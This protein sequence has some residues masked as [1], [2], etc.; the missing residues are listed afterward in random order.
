MTQLNRREEQK[1]HRKRRNKKKGKGKDKK[2]NVA[3][4]NERERERRICQRKEEE[5]EEEKEKREKHFQEDTP[6]LNYSVP[7]LS[8]I[9]ISTRRK[10]KQNTRAHRKRGPSRLLRVCMHAIFALVEQPHLPRPNQTAITA[11]RPSLHA[12]AT[13]QNHPCP[14]LWPSLER[15]KNNLDLPV[16]L[17]VKTP[18]AKISSRSSSAQQRNRLQC[19]VHDRPGACLHLHCMSLPAPAV[20]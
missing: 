15:E 17:T 19:K 16:F 11:A 9:P 7:P 2:G 14:A 18:P 5:E 6:S 1:K 3:S 4:R 12:S 10:Q 20:Q 8:I 13:S